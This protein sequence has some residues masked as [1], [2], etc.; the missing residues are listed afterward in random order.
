MN[1][2]K[3]REQFGITQRKLA[4][5]LGIPPTTLNKYENNLTEP[6]ISTLVKLADYF[7]ITIDE[8]VGRPT[9]LIN[10]MVLTERRQTVIDK[11]I[12]MNDKQ[13]ELTEFFINTLNN[14]I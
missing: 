10:R 14:S 8:L 3:Y 7:H 6:N 9:S 2:T 11:V 1:L 13:V 12:Q 4:F 5:D